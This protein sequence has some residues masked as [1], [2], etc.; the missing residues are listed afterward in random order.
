MSVMASKQQSCIV[1]QCPDS[2]VRFD[3]ILQC[4]RCSHVYA[5]LERYVSTDLELLYQ[6]EYFSGAEYSDYVAD[7]PVLQQ[8]FR[9]RLRVLLRFVDRAE[10]KSLLEIGC[11]H[12][13]F[14]DVAGPF[15]ARVEGID[16]SAGAVT[17]A[18]ERVGVRAVCGNFLSHDY[19]GGLFDVICLWDTL[20]H[21]PE[22]HRFLAK[23]F[24][25]LNDGGIIALT[26][27]D[28]GSAVAKLR[29][30]KWRLIHPPTHLHYFSRMS[31]RRVLRN[32]G[33]VP[34][35]R[36]SCGFSRSA[37]NAAHGV[38]ALRLGR[39]EL[40]QWLRKHGLLGWSFNLNLFD[41]MYV[42][43][44]KRSLSEGTD[45]VSGLGK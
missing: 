16:I 3:G 41:I 18:R 44:R 32:Q 17:Y 11:A 35:Y 7:R 8:N 43:A 10:D 40:Y 27:G 37:D 36:S 42:I 33:F 28:I 5:D 4:T 14:L 12:G 31:M 39:P 25:C 1:C 20:E 9:R 38:L 23:A 34:V 26:T 30:R 13:F 21:L 45:Q 2:T 6:E 19:Q 22:P 24:R 15:F 29:G